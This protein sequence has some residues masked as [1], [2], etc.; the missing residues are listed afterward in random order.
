[1]TKLS[2]LQLTVNDLSLNWNEDPKLKARPCQICK[3]PTK[4]RGQWGIVRAVICM[5]CAIA[6]TFK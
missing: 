2:V 3:L 5:S 1:M 4:G 6:E